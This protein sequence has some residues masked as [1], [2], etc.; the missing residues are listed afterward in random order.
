MPPMLGTK[1]IAEGAIR[2]IIWASWPAPEVIRL[3]ASPRSR[4]A[5]STSLTILLI[6]LYRLEPCQPLDRD[7]DLLVSRQRLQ[8]MW[9]AQLPPA[10]RRSSS[11]S[12]RSTVKI[13]RDGMTLIAF[14]SKRDAADRRDGR[15]VRRLARSRRKVTTRAAA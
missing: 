15:R 2:A 13:A 9:Q 1:I 6:E 12:R 3:E 14:G 8:E 11:G 10:F 4:A 5:S 7:V